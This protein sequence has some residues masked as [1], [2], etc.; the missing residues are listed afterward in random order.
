MECWNKMKKIGS[1]LYF[2]AN[3]KRDFF[4]AIKFYQKFNGASKE[5]THKI[6]QNKIKE[7][8]NGEEVSG[9]RI[10]KGIF[11]KPAYLVRQKESSQNNSQYVPVSFFGQTLEGASQ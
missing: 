7:I 1:T 5:E 10:T 6:I 9:Y 3:Q 4:R 2:G 11:G 8:E